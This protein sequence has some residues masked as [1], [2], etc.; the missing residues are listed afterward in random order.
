M[1]TPEQ[2]RD[3]AD[4]PPGEGPYNQNSW[5]YEPP[6][7]RGYLVIED[8]LPFLKGRKVDDVVRGYIHALR[9]SSVRICRQGCPMDAQTWR[10]TIWID[11]NDLIKSIHQEVETGGYGDIHNGSSLRCA[12]QGR[13]IPKPSPDGSYMGLT[14]ANSAALHRVH[15]F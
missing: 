15:F 14:L 5:K 7:K 9:P 10:V 4:F 1:N 3:W 2:E 12:L 6:N 13:P 8:L 11:E